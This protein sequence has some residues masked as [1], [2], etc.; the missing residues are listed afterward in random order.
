MAPPSK[1]FDSIADAEIDVDSPLTTG[2][3][4]KLRDRD[5]HLEEWLGGSFVAAVDHDHDGANS[6]KVVSDQ[7]PKNAE[8]VTGRDVT[9]TSFIDLPGASV[10]Y[11]AAE[12][13]VDR[14]CL[15]I[16]ALDCQEVSGSPADIEFAL[17]IDGVDKQ[18][19]RAK[20]QLVEHSPVILAGQNTLIAGADR[21]IK[22]RF[23]NLSASGTNRVSRSYLQAFLMS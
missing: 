20:T 2:L 6:K 10:T 5:V 19:M 22:V 12:L 23:R 3:L 15:I 17:N 7:N 1:N 21:I 14:E 9:V 13:L 18:F 4:T 8:D 16:V 11:T